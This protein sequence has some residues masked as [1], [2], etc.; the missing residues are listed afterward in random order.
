MGR[1][2]EGL[3]GIKHRRVVVSEGRRWRFDLVMGRELFGD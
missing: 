2:G 1:R 3:G